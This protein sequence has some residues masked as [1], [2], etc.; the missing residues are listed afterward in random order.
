MRRMAREGGWSVI[1][2]WHMFW[3]SCETGKGSPMEEMFGRSRKILQKVQATGY[4]DNDAIQ[5]GWIA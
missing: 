2:S 1:N 3:A 4:V 5:T